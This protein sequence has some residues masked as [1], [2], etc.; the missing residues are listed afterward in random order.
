[1]PAKLASPRVTLDE[2]FTHELA[3]EK[4]INIMVGDLQRNW[5]SVANYKID[6]ARGT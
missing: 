3:A 1:M 4:I 6:L 5:V 2:Y